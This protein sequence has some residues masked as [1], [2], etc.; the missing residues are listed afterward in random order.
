[1]SEK[2]KIFDFKD[3]RTANLVRVKKNSLNKWY[4][5]DSQLG[6]DGDQLTETPRA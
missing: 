4:C 3:R 1:M 6:N 5:L 2:V